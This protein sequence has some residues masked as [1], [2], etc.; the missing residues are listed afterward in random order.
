MAGDTGATGESSWTV[1]VN[2]ACSQGCTLTQ[3]YWKTHSRKG[4][5]PGG[6]GRPVGGQNESA[7]ITSFKAR[8]ARARRGI[9]L[10]VDLRNWTWPS[11][12]IAAASVG[13]T[14]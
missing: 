4:P 12:M 1:N 6:S 2:V 13:G 5:A 10:M 8:V 3:G 7:E 11:R 9:G 14:L